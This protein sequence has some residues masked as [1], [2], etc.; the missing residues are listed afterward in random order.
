MPIIQADSPAVIA[1]VRQ[2]IKEID[3]VMEHVTQGDEAARGLGSL[4]YM[5]GWIAALE[6]EG[7]LSKSVAGQLRGEAKQAV[8]AGDDAEPRPERPKLTPAEAATLLYDR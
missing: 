1:R 3:Q 4:M 2:Q 7:L 5:A 6:A 8:E